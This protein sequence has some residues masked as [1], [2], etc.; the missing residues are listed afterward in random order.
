MT[1]LDWKEDYETGVAE[2]D[3]EH[4]EIVDLVN[5]AYARL[6][7]GQSKDTVSRCLG[8]IYARISAHFA[9]EERLMRS[10]GYDEYDPHK[11][12]HERLLDELRDFMD[13]YDA[14]AAFDP[15]LFGRI[16]SDWFAIHF[17]TFDARL[18]RFT[19]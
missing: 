9:L 17:R 6:S 2:V 18:H 19:G 5:D 1:L 7:A 16:L 3:Q 10:V 8:D 13:E 12:D 14:V 15:V 11:T 4:R